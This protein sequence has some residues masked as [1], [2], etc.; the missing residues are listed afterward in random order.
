MMAEQYP[1]LEEIEEWVRVVQDKAQQLLDSANPLTPQAKFDELVKMAQQF[2]SLSR[3]FLQLGTIAANA[4]E[5]L[6]PQLPGE[7]AEPG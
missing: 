2:F 6:S 1:F 4:A 7:R 5:S 3:R